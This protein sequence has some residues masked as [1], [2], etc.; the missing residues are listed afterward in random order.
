MLKG[1]STVFLT[2]FFLMICF[3][4]DEQYNNAKEL[5]FR[6]LKLDKVL[7]KR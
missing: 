5:L 2:V 4:Q 6:L 7:K 1:L 3:R